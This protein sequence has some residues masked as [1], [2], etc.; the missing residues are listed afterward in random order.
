M[1]ITSLDVVNTCLATL[2]EVPLNS[3]DTDHPYVSAATKLLQQANARVQARGWWFNK[4]IV[5]LQPDTESAEITLPPDFLSLDTDSAQLQY[6]ARG[7]RL[8]DLSAGSYRFTD[9]V[10]LAIV[11]LLKFEDLPYLAQDLVQSAVI[12]RFVESYD[13]DESRIKQVRADYAL[14]ERACNTEHIRN[15][16]SNLLGQGAAGYRRAKLRYPG[17][18]HQSGLRVR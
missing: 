16:N 15:S 10:D 3:L 13:A 14:A 17:G 7:R 9:S 5:T 1:F 6:A 2:G 8:Y 4:E 11:R 18:F 12:V